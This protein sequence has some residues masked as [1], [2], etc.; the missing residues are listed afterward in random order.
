MVPR[1]E[2][3]SETRLIGKKAI[4]S[5]ANNKTVELWQSFSPGRKEIKNPVSSDLYSVDIYNDTNFFAD[6]NPLKE[7]EK[8]AAIKVKDFDTIPVEMDKLTIPEGQYAVFHYRG[9]PSEAQKTFQY[10]YGIWLP[11]S[12]FEMD[13]RPYFA[14]MGEK[15]K[16]EDPESEEEFWIPIKKKA[17]STWH[18]V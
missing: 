12:N 3:L 15:Y 11:D 8:W 18:M 14:L 7:F 2:S 6:F 10:I 16:G 4:M 9:K 1:I 5:F 13:D 17:T